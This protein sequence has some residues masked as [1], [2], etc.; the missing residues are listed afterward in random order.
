[1]L[2]FAVLLVSAAI[3]LSATPKFVAGDLLWVS[4][5]DSRIY[6]IAASSSKVNGGSR[7]PFATVGHQQFGQMAFD[8]SGTTA[9]I[10]TWDGY[11]MSIDNAGN[12]KEFAR[13]LNTP[14]GLVRTSTGKLLVASYDDGKIFDITA[15]GD[16]SAATAWAYGLLNPR[17]LLETPNGIYVA[18]QGSNEITN[19]GKGGDLTLAAAHATIG[20]PTSMAWYKD[21]LYAVSNDNMNVYAIA[22]AG[23]VNM[24]TPY[25]KGKEFSS[26]ATA[27]GHLYSGTATRA[28][29]LLDSGIWDVSAGG[30]YK[31]KPA[32]IYNLPEADSIL[33]IVPEPTAAPVPLP[34]P[35]TGMAAAGLLMLIG[36][37][38][39]RRR[40]RP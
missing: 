17:S 1:V 7:T 19:V 13:G 31:T 29:S 24:S 3:W 20:A 37:A 35:G 26:L 25:A 15:G 18:E 8:A 12:V 21:K 22:T 30:D 6:T 38:S 9:Y 36:G 32:M 16:F 4:T 14:T 34:E 23:A 39:W 28:S 10:T 40:A 33:G 2:R 5:E 27:D 11:V